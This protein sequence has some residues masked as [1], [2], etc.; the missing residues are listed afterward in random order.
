M[1]S[2]P[3]PVRIMLRLNLNEPRIGMEFAQQFFAGHQV[4]VATHTDGH[5]RGGNLHV[6]IALNSLRKLD[7]PRQD[8]MERD[9]DAK[10][11]YKHHV[12][13]H[14]LGECSRR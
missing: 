12:T 2:H 7:E 11:G 4:L 1:T 14:L 3:N 5:N 13:R 8:F 6:H 9:I 10:A